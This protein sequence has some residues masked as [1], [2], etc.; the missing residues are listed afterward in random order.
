MIGLIE[1][2]AISGKA[3]KSVFEEMFGSGRSAGE[4][5]SESDLTQISDTEELTGIV[6]QVLKENPDAVSDYAAGKTQASRFLVGQ[7]MKATRG[8]ANPQVVDGLLTQRLGRMG[9]E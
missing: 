3:A 7:V 4:I 6:D 5:I 8:K 2:G 1:D 9:Q